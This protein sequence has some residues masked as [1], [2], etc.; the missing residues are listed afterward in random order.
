MLWAEI[1]Y[2]PRHGRSLQG[3]GDCF[4]LMRD[5]LCFGE[6][7]LPKTMR[8]V[9]VLLIT[10]S[11]ASTLDNIVVINEILFGSTLHAACQAR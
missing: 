8:S 5:C 9:V 4:W 7:S 11:S 6:E 10:R 2:L 1:K 3:M